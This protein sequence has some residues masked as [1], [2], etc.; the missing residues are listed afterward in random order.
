LIASGSECVR[1]A[2]LREAAFRG[3][4][5]GHGSDHLHG[6]GRS[7]LAELRARFRAAR[8]FCSDFRGI[9]ILAV[10]AHLLKRASATSASS[11]AAGSATA[12]ADAASRAVIRFGSTWF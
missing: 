10:Q 3:L 8:V 4:P 1:S 12:A 6:V 11:A 7:G 5:H 9:L 2:G